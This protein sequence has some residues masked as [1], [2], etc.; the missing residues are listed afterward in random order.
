[1]PSLSW[2]FCLDVVD[3][4]RGLHVKRDGLAR[5]RIHEDLHPPP[6]TQH[7]VRRRLLLDVVFRER[8]PVF[9]PLAFED[10]APLVWE[11]APLLSPCLCLS[12]GLGLGLGP[13]HP[14]S[15]FPNP[16]TRDPPSCRPA[17]SWCLRR[18]R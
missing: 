12:L 6:Q 3:G 9:E 14:S 1:M 8:A 2:I 5:Q 10:R 17:E 7:Q 13:D 16:E 15:S 11:D 4:V 18:S